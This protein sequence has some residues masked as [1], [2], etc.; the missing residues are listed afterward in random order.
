MAS[1]ILTRLIK[2]PGI[3]V[4]RT[5]DF[6]VQKFAANKEVWAPNTFPFGQLLRDNKTVFL[7]EYNQLLNEKEIRNVKDFFIVETDIN[8]DE[9][10]KAAPLVLFRY[11]FKENAERCPETFKII[12]KLPGCCGAMFS[13]L[14]PGKYIPPHKGIYK[15][16]YRC[17]L[18]LK[19]APNADC[20]IRV[21]NQKLYF[22]E[23]E[24]IVFDETVEHEVMNASAFPRVVLFLDLYRK[25]PFPL[26]VLN[27]VI[28]TLLRKSPF[29]ANILNEYN[30]LE[31]TSIENFK[32]SEAI[33]G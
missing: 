20:W 21:N 32:P 7:R 1:K 13:V 3:A 2:I 5:F 24:C 12:S 33:L 22:E 26:N 29:V 25:L 14:G 8:Q 23:G 17:L 4:L 27:H 16:A 6:L 30:K 19:V 10:W 28:F 18:T 11:L 15:G 9:N 31:K